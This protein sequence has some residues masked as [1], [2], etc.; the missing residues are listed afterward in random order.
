MGG[1]VKV[2]MV[3]PAPPQT[4]GMETF[5]GELLG[6]FLPNEFDL[7]LLNIAKIKL[8]QRTK[9]REF[10][11]YDTIF[12]RRLWLSLWSYS[13]SFFFFWKFLFLLIRFRP[14]IVHIHTASYTSFW[15]KVSY[16][17]LAKLLGRKIVLHSHGGFFQRFYE[18]GS[19]PA[20]WLIRTT[21]N[22]CDRIAVLSE[23]WRQF[24][25][26]IAKPE[27]I[28]VVP[29][30]IDLSQFNGYQRKPSDQPSFV[31]VGR[32]SRAKGVYDLVDAAARVVNEGRSC[33]IY[34]LGAGEI[35][36]VKTQSRELG[37]ENFIH[38]PGPVYGSQ[39]LSY[40]SKA[41]CFV[42]PSH[43]EAMPITI[44][45]AYAAGLPVICTRVGAV[46]QM[47]DESKNGFLFDPKDIDELASH[48]EFIIDNPESAFDMGQENE[49][50]ARE[51]YDIQ[52]TAR[53]VQKIYF[54]LL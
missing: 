22:R 4:G 19:K 31:F 40:L 3:A 43:G 45:E 18:N 2:L 33:H 42:L 52:N 10:V 44:L 9:S 6:T 34:F 1:R 41:W 8:N 54:E 20:Q 12:R 38:L 53:I 30:G 23:S 36:E 7:K 11:G 14:R 37:I 29:N 47:V 46:P 17:Y 21:L 25:Q 49:R 24:Y 51:Q 27:K 28:R 15:E 32:I 48:I 5:V 26:T 16:I 13:Y 39:K 50:L 35:D